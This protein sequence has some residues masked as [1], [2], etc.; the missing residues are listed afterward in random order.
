M[1]DHLRDL[2][3]MF[4]KLAAVGEDVNDNHKLAV[5]LR[6]VHNCYPTLMTALLSNG[7]DKLTLVFVKKELL[8]KEQKQGKPTTSP[9]GVTESKGSEADLNIQKFG[10][11]REYGVCLNCGQQSQ[12]I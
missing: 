12:F 9:G 6:S 3:E 2:D 1:Q 8:D 5:L 7:N 11:I 4:D 10:R